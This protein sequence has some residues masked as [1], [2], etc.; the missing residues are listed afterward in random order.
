VP[1]T[2]WSDGNV[3]TAA[4]YNSN[5]RDQ[6]ISTVT[7]ATRPSGTEG[8]VIYETDTDL[9]YIYNGGWIRFG[10]GGGWTSYTPT[11]TQS[12]AVTKTVTYAKYEKVGRMVSVNVRLDVTGTG[13]AN[14]GITITVPFTAATGG[15]WTG[16]GVIYDFSASTIYPCIATLFTTGTF[17]LSDATAGHTVNVYQG[18]TGSAF[19]AALAASDAISF[20]M[21]YEAAS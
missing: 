13:T 8:Q 5:F 11:L 15:L 4:Q 18:Q 6:V 17:A 9:L 21:T 3:P 1:I 19:S 10:A 7:S 2:T 20:G 16:A 14:N 12:G